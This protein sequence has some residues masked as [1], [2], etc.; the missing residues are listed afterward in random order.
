MSDP[1]VV[2]A[3]V[4][5]TS[6]LT[7]QQVASWV[8]AAQIACTRDFAP[9]WCDATLAFVRPGQSIPTG[10]YQLWLNDRS[11]EADA[12]GYHDDQ[13]LPISHVGVL[14]AADDGVAWSV[15]ASHEL[16]E[17][18]ADP[19]IDKTVTFVT[20]DTT[21]EIPLEVADAPEDDRFAYKVTGPDSV[22][23]LTSAFV[24]RS[25]FDPA[26]VAPFTFPLIAVIDA[27]FKLAAGGFIG[28]REGSPVPSE[29][30]QEFAQ[31]RGPRDV[32]RPQSRTMRRFIRDG[33]A[34][35]GTGA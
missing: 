2:V 34:S 21:Y 8:A 4:R 28:M 31:T 19:K 11:G 5:N 35:M 18:L 9:H 29:W 33:L 13:G 7:D 12:L 3:V 20:G 25:W 26:G 16:W 23:H 30:R 1:A 14:D 6:A 22:F 27:P 32:K 15:T 10:A 17:M 24:L